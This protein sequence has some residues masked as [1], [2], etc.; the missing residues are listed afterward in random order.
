MLLGRSAFLHIPKCGGSSIR[1]ALRNAGF[2]QK[3]EDES[4]PADLP[5]NQRSHAKLAAVI[6][7]CGNR[8]LFTFIREPVA[9]YRSYWSHRTNFE[10][11]V[12][13]YLEE[14]EAWG[15]GKSF[16]VWVESI[17]QLHPGFLRRLYGEYVSPRVFVGRTEN[18]QHDLN[19]ALSAAGEGI[20]NISVGR[21]NS[22]ESRPDVTD[23]IANLIANSEYGWHHHLNAIDPQTNPAV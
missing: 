20:Q 6:E 4:G 23:E 5:F 21:E 16:P 17:C 2:S 14:R 10:W 12:P 9:W 3:S 18:L 11:T 8:F 13:Q 15:V 22:S 1:I 19:V 7:E